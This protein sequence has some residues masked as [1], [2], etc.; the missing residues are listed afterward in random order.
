MLGAMIVLPVQDGFVK[1]LSE[2]LPV[3]TVV[4]ARYLFHLLLLIPLLTWRLS[5][6]QLLPR[7]PGVQLLRALAM[8]TSGLL[9]FGALAQLPLVDALALFFISPLVVTLLAPL[10]LGERVSWFRRGAV[11]IGFLGVL[12]VLRPGSTTWGPYALMALGSGVVHA[13]YLII[14]RKLAGSAPPLATI[15]FGTLFGTVALSAWV[16]PR[17][18]A[19]TPR[20]W[21]L[22][23]TLGMLAMVGHYLVV[24]A[25]DYAPAATLAPLGY[26]EI[27]SATLVGYLLFGDFPDAL[28]WLGVAVII[29]SGLV[30]TLRERQ[31]ALSSV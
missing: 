25:F 3:P 29:G 23:A 9:F 26:A 4:W 21:L 20:E 28:S 7:Q 14:T 6:A 11:A 22:M 16:L 2:N 27:I 5:P 8:L 10:L 15:A 31:R 19:P 12:I 24:K 30:V 13:L 17:W 18:I 1:L